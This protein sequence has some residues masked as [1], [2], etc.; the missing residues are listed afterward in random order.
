MKNI[1][2][3]QVE[4]GFWKLEFFLI[5]P[6]SYRK[7]NRT[8]PLSKL[9][10]KKSNIIP[11]TCVMYSANLG[12]T[13]GYLQRMFSTSTTSG[14]VQII[15]HIFMYRWKW[16]FENSDLFQFHLILT[17]ILNVTSICPNCFQNIKYYFKNMRNVF[18]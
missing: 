9:L 7:T 12:D 18:S 4:V 17:A 2:H 8:F 1:F 6:Y 3:V 11:K 5:S 15:K 14:K 16:D 13:F 10:L